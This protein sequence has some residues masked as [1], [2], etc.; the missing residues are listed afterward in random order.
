MMKAA[1][2]AGGTVMATTALRERKP[3]WLRVRFPGGENYL[4]LKS[5]MR[6]KEL[7]TVCEEARCPNIG[8]CWQAGTATFMILGDTC[9]RACSFCAITTGRPQ[10]LD[11]EEPWRVAEAVAAMALQHAVVTSV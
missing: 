5:L 10:A 1:V 8:E 11:F 4:R 9:T 2:S 6:A 7:H 3:E